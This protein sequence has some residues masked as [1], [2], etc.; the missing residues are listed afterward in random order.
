[1]KNS[2]DLEAHQ[3]TLEPCVRRESNVVQYL[4]D[5]EKLKQL[6]SRRKTSKTATEAERWAEMYRIIFPNFEHST[7]KSCESFIARSVTPHARHRTNPYDADYEPLDLD[8]P[9]AHRLFED[10]VNDLG[11]VIHD[12][13]TRKDV[14]SV[15][16]NSVYRWLCPDPANSTDVGPVAQSTEPTVASFST[17]EDVEPEPGFSLSLSDSSVLDFSWPFL[18]DSVSP[19]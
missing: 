9:S 15:L 3:R 4:L 7:P 17:A 13:H 18:P 5:E 10:V 1:M 12:E 2:G 16:E 11:S 8:Q 14:V 19:A 6:K